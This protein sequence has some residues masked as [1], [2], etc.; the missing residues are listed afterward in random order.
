MG[1]G[2]AAGGRVGRRVGGTGVDVH[3]E[4]AVGN[5]VSVQVGVLVGVRVGNRVL[6]GL[7]VGVLVGT[8]RGV[9]VHVAG[10][11]IP[12]IF[13]Q[14]GEAVF[15]RIER[16]CVLRASRMGEVVVAL[17]GGAITEEANWETI[18]ETGICLCL[19]ASPETIFKRVR[20]ADDRPLM[21]GLD[22]AARMA[23]IRRMLAER[24][25]FYRRADAFVTSTED[26]T[27]AETADLALAALER[28]AK[29]RR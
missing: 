22:D 15:R 20:R 6:V 26:R 21:A 13:A 29:D 17:G 5:G 16:A 27:P 25:P 28:I 19:R 4:V 10:K 8:G 11:T 12:E 7:G 2:V 24:E 3:V 18:R 23:R 14:D 1:V 9:G